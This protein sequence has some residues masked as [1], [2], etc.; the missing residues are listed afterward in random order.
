MIK[1]H[2]GASDCAFAHAI[3]A[4]MVQVEKNVLQRISTEV[5]R[6]LKTDR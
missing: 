1:S 5:E 3:E 4:G 2:G 6:I